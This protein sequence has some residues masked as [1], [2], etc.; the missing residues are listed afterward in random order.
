MSNPTDPIALS[1]AAQLRANLAEDFSSEDLQLLCYDLQVDYDDLAGDS[2]ATK[3][4]CLLENL[5]RS[6]RIVQLIDRCAQLRPGRSW[7]ELHSAATSNPALFKPEELVYATVKSNSILNLP[8]DRALRLGFGLGIVVVIVLLCGFSGGLLAGKFVNITLDPVPSNPAVGQAAREELGVLDSF[9]SG[10]RAQVVYDNEK[11]TSLGQELLTKPDSPIGEVHVQ[12]LDGEEISLNMTVKA[13]G[14]RRVVMGMKA[15]AVNGRLVL[16]PK[17][18]AI[19]VLGLK[20]TTFGW[21][22]IPTG[23]IAP[24]T[25]WLQ[26][27]LDEAA[28]KY[29]FNDIQVRSNW[30][31]VDL[32]RR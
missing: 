14:N 30:M 28:R 2:K 9:P 21:I 32:T 25:N 17:A 1:P 29:W 10:T 5:G 15:H 13:L 31:M 7:A 27:R 20:R 4:V 19:D 12:F 23:F 11:A 24:V 26:Q 8:A 18:V 6:G 16:E 22:A 3:I